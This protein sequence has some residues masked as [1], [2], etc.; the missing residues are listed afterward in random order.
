MHRI[1]F[2]KLKSP[3]RSLLR[4]MAIL[5]ALVLVVELLAQLTFYL[6]SAGRVDFAALASLPSPDR[7]PS[8]EKAV[9]QVAEWPAD[10]P[11]LFREAPQ[12][13]ILVES[14]NLPPVADRLPADPQIIIPPEQTG[15]YGGTWTRYGT[16]P[17]DIGIFG[18]RLAYDGLIRWGPMGREI[19]PNLAS[20]WEITDDGHPFTADD[21]LF[22][23]TDVLQD[24]DLTPVIPIE[25]RPG[26]QLMQLDKL[27]DYTIP[28]S[29]RTAF[30]T[31]P[32]W[33]WAAGPCAPLAPPPP[34]ATPSTRK[35]AEPCSS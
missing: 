13:K 6:S 26:D 27:D 33:P 17:G 14:G 31:S 21:I 23:Y 4:L 10:R 25:Y 34:N 19:R 20:S 15:P 22:W 28:S 18:H 12:W 29:S 16:G 3:L 5:F 30:A 9:H 24:S 8:R 32:R 2:T 7:H 35:A 1:S 11:R